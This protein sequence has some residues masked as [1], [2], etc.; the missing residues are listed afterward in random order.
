MK[1]S[2]LMEEIA[3]EL[4]DSEKEYGMA[5]RYLIQVGK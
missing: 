4:Q 3:N 2:N 1:S 5:T